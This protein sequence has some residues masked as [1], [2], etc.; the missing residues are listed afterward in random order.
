MEW[1]YYKKMLLSVDELFKVV[2]LV[3]V[4]DTPSVRFARY[5]R[6]LKISTPHV[7]SISI[8]IFKKRHRNGP[9]VQIFSP[10]GGESHYPPLP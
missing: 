1:F 2:K 3:S 7:V 10:L 9:N 6:K 5:G 8:E 4:E